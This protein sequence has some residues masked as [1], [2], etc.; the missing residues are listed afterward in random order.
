MGNNFGA[1]DGCVTE[2]LVAYYNERAKG[3]PGLII[4]EMVSI[5]S[6]LGRRGTNQLRIDEDRYIDGLSSLT[7]QIH[8]STCKIAIQL[9]HAG[10]F[11]AS[12]YVQVQPVAPS[13][14]EYFGQKVTEELSIFQIENI[15][16][17]FVDGARRAQAANFDGVE[18]HA[19]HSY[20]LAHFLS[21]VFN[22]RRDVFGGSIENRARI[23]TETIS[24]IKKL[25]GQDF[26]VWCR[27]NGMEY[28]L[29]G[30]LTIDEAK[31]IARMA[32]TAGSNAIHVSAGAYGHYSGYNR[33]G[34]GQPK[35]NLANLAAQIKKAVKVPVI[36]VGRIDLQL[37]EQLLRESQVDLVAIGRAQIAD[38]QIVAKADEGR[39]SD[40]RPCIGCNVC[41]DDLTSL[42]I[43]LHCSVNANVG[44]EQDCKMT[45]PQKIKNILVIG[46][47][48][49]GL[50]T[51]ITA[52][53]R[54]HK[55]TIQEKLPQL[56]GKL[57]LAAT[58]PNKEE[59]RPFINYL[60]FQVNKLGIK[61]ELSKEADIAS[62]K[63]VH[64]D[65]VVLASG[66]LAVIPQI[67]GIES[68]NVV[69]AEN[70]LSG[71]DIGQKVVIIGG[72]LVGCET[73][74]Y[75]VAK[76]KTVTILEILD[77]IATGVGLSFK[78]G[79]IESLTESGVNLLTS[80][81]CEKIT[82]TVVVIKNNTGDLQTIE[83]DNIVL[84]AGAKPNN[85]LFKL[86]QQIVPE[87]Y[88]VGDCVEPRRILEAVS[89][90]HRIGSII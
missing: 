13:P 89:E 63:Q 38:P 14:I 61:A 73:A 68:K 88:M 22:K 57:I 43:S 3:G 71:I 21:P 30:G 84:A 66:G 85:G 19:A 81:S 12:K 7:R 67:P 27:I 29:E 17:R 69:L 65:V 15:I 10:L 41:V 83:A 5:D 24:R 59:I 48:P 62:I 75:L 76:G 58:P 9:C 33:A 74:E 51:A 49:S 36:A 82:E 77:Q 20:L 53:L 45:P 87:V 25:L 42:D 34:M 80:V 4:T 56:G 28:G 55:V 39:V 31:E 1:E 18:V 32:E 44:K 23:L 64:P 35:G 79:L 90:G 47:G 16:N 70:V 72:G 60:V 46:G 2:R 52:T 8:N 37:G 78:D 6:P 40:I 26:P 54:G 86:I 50:E 11:A